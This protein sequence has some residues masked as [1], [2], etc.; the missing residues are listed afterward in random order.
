MVGEFIEKFDVVLLDFGFLVGFIILFDEV[1]VDIGVKIM[2][3][4]VKEFGLCF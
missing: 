3:I 1:G 4:L 2:L